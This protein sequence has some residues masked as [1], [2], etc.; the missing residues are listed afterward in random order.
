MRA[1]RR[2]PPGP[3]QGFTYVGLL[4]MLALLGIALSV[5]GP[6]WSDAVRREREQDLL[7]VGRLYAQALG[8]YQRNGPGSV[9]PY[10][11]TL[12]A[13][14]EDRRHLGTYRYLRQLYP[15]P[16]DPSRPWGL[17][18]DSSNGIRGVYST[19]ALAPLR[20]EALDLGDVTLPAAKSY[21]EWI[22]APPPPSP[23]SSPRTQP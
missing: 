19:S 13:L 20:R 3:A 6:L 4:A 21:Q 18:R 5:V 22:F 11:E 16:I 8:A 7:R 9:Q 17:V 14:L 12:E 1:G 15:D 23:A 2:H 10:P